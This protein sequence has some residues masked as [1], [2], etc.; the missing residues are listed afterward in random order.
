M[1]AVYIAA[2]WNEYREVRAVIFALR[3]RGCTITHDW[4]QFVDQYPKDQA[5]RKSRSIM[6]SGT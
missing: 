6:R 3:T 1:T 5:P 2:P 4:T